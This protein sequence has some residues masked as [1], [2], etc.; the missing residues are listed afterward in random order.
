MKNNTDIRWIQR[1]DNYNKALSKLTDAVQLDQTKTLS[2]LEKQGLI[3]SFEYTHE[4]AWKVMKDYFTFQGN[5]EITGSR[6]AT[7]Q[8]FKANLIEDGDN[9]LKMIHNRNLTSHTYNEETSEEIYENIVTIFYPLFVLFQKKMN[10]LKEKN[11]E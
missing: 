5:T 7:R 10:Q 1:L 8:A 6:D 3:Q 2:E 11:E 9:W 4:L